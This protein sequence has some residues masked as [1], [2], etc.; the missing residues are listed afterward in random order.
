M[1]LW[2]IRNEPT[3]GKM[4]RMARAKPMA[5]TDERASALDAVRAFGVMLGG[6]VLLTAAAAASVGATAAALARRRR[7]HPVAVA[8]TVASAAYAL[9]VHPWLGSWGAHAEERVQEL[10]GDDYVPEA[11]MQATRAVT[12]EAPLEEVW[13]WL[14]QIGQDRA[15]FYS[16]EWLENLAGCRMKNAD[17]IHPEWQERTVGEMVKLH[18]ANGLELTRFEPN[19]VFA[20][21]GWYLLL[22]G[23]DGFTRLIARS[24]F[25]RGSASLAYGVFLELPHFIMERRM[26]LGIKERAERARKEATA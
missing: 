9:V 18:W 13:P 3:T 22:K 14:A 15:G 8:G 23:D 1:R 5:A 26:L 25:P 11:G 21:G 19:R 24:R 12:I 20:L 16:Y 7:P 17:R 4:P 2:K 6:S 10:P